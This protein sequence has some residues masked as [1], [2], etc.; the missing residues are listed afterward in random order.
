MSSPN[1]F[2]QQVI[3]AVTGHMNT[4]HPED[5]VLIVKALGGRPDATGAVMTG[6]DGAGADFEATVEGGPVT[7][8]VPWSKQLTD[9]PEIRLEVVRMYNEACE[10][11]GL[12]PRGAQ[13]H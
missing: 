5:N 11:L 1:P 8:R 4:D 12:E 7:I 3:D 2:D 6:L 13:E 10:I 9:R